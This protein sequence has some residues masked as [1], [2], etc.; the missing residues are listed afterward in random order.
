VTDDLPPTVLKLGGSLLELPGLRERLAGVIAAFE[1]PALLVG[2][3]PTT[4]VVR[5]MD[6]LHGLGEEASH[7]LATRGLS[8]NGHIVAALLGRAAVVASRA[9]IAA[10]WAAGKTPVLDAIAFLEQDAHQS[11]EPLP[12]TW[13]AASDAVGARIARLLAARQYVLIKSAPLP[14]GIGVIEAARRGIVDEWFPH[15]AVHLPRIVYVDLRAEPPTHST[16]GVDG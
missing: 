13:A 11:V 6:R 3:G 2:G 16:L 1:R 15:E 5:M 10:A 7:W 9:E 12:H 8:L 14:E 4:D